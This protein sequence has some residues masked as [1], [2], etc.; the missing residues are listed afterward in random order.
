MER[1]TAYRPSRLLCALVLLIGGCLHTHQQS[2]SSLSAEETEQLLAELPPLDTRAEAKESPSAPSRTEPLRPEKQ[3]PTPAFTQPDAPENSG[4]KQPPTL[5]RHAP[6]GEVKRAQLISLSFSEPMIPIGRHRNNV[7]PPVNLNPAVEGTWRWLDTQS[8]VFEPEGGAFPMATDFTVSVTEK[9][10]SA[11]DIPLEEPFE[12]TFSTPRLQITDFHPGESEPVSQQPVLVI[13]FNQRID[14]DHLINF[15]E[16]TNGEESYSL[17]QADQ[18]R[19][20]RD[21]DGAEAFIDN[22]DYE[23]WLALVPSEPLPQGRSFTLTLREDAPAPA[24]PRRTQTPVTQTFQTAG[25]LQIA[26]LPCGQ[27][28]PCDPEERLLVRL[29]HG[30]AESWDSSLLSISP[31]VPDFRVDHYS[32]SLYLSGDFAPKT[33]YTLTLKAG[34]RDRFGQT[35]QQDLTTRIKTGDYTP[36]FALPGHKWI[37]L[38][39]AFSE[40]PILSRNTDHLRVELRKV[41]PSDWE[42]FT[43]YRQRVRQSSDKEPADKPGELIEM[44]NIRPPEGQRPFVRTDIPLDK[45]LNDAG[46]GHVLVFVSSPD[47][48]QDYTRRHPNNQATMGTWVQVTDLGLSAYTTSRKTTAWVTSLV[49]GRAIEGAQVQFEQA[50]AQTDSRG[51]AEL[52][53]ADTLSELTVTK[54]EDQAFFPSHQ[55]RSSDYHRAGYYRYP[56]FLFSDRGLYQPGEKAHF[57]GIIR[58]RGEGPEGDIQRPSG[59]THIEWT[60]Y[61]GQDNELD[62]GTAPLDKA[63]AFDLQLA[64]PKN[65]ASGTGHI[66]VRLFRG[67][68]PVNQYEAYHGFAIE[69]FRRPEYQ[70]DLQLSEAH[71]LPKE[72]LY[73]AV[74]AHYYSGG[75]LTD[76]P[77]DWQFELKASHYAPPGWPDYQFGQGRPT[78]FGGPGPT[79]QTTTWEES[80]SGRTD[81]AGKHRL[82][83]SPNPTL[84]FDNLHFPHRLNAEAK[85]TDINRQQWASRGE[86]QVHPASLYVGLR[87]HAPFARRGETITV[88]WVTVNI[89]GEAVEA[90]PGF[91]IERME[92]TNDE[93]QVTDKQDCQSENTASQCQFTPEQSGHYRVTA[94]VRDSQ[95]RESRTEMTVWVA[96]KNSSPQ[97]T[98]TGQPEIQMIP[99]KE[100]Y[101]PG[102][103]ARVQVQTPFSPAEL[104]MTVQR[105]GLVS[106][107]YQSLHDGSYTLEIPIRE[108]SMPTLSITAEAIAPATDSEGPRQA[109]QTLSLPVTTDSRRLTVDLDLEQDRLKPGET[110]NVAIA[111]SNHR[112]QP[113][114]GG[115]VTLYAVDEAVLETAGY[116]LPE[117][118]STFYSHIADGVREYRSRDRLVHLPESPTHELLEEVTASGVRASVGMAPPPTD[119]AARSGIDVR[120]DFSALATFE[121]SVKLDENGKASVSFQLPDNLT[122]YRLMAVAYTDRHFGAGESELEVGLPLMVRPSLPRFLNLGDRAELPVVVQNTTDQPMTVDLAL[123]AQNLA[124]SGSLGRRITVPAKDRRELRFAAE[125]I[126]AGEARIQVIARAGDFQDAAELSLPVQTPASAE[127]FAQ[128]GSLTQGNHFLGLSVPEAVYPD[129]GGLSLTT[130]ST[131]IPSLTDAFIHLLDYPYG[132]SEQLASR[133]MAIATLESLITAFDAERI[134]EP[135]AME[136]SVEKILA[137]LKERQNRDGGW[138]FW[139]RNQQSSPYLSTHV[140]HA[141]LRARDAGYSEA[142]TL[143]P[144]ALSYVE[145]LHKHLPDKVGERQRYGALSYSYYV[146]N[147]EEK[148][149]VKQARQLLRQADRDQLSAETLGWLLTVIDD[150]EELQK[151]LRRRLTNRLRETAGTAQF[152]DDYPKGGHWL[153]HGSR[154]TDAVVL[155]ALLSTGHENDLAEKLVRG[156]LDRRKQ[157]HWG[158][159]QENAFALLALKRYFDTYETEQPNLVARAWLDQRF[160]SEHRYRGR[161]TDSHT[162]TLGMGQ[163]QAGNPESTLTLQHQGSGRLYYRLGLKYAPVDMQSKAASHGFQVERRYEAVNNPDEV[164]QR[165]DGSWEIASGAAVRVK[166]TM[167]I[168]ARRHHVALTDHLPAGL[169]PL[170]PALENTAQQDESRHRQSAPGPWPVPRWYQHHQLRDDRAEA[171]STQLEAGVYHYEYIALAT[172]PGRFVV[173]PAEAEEMYRPETFGRSA[174]DT[175][176]VVEAF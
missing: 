3:K 20:Q 170:N 154:R 175:L 6:Q 165:A 23:H 93:W 22:L 40:L 80:A 107:H 112:D 176:R 90:E 69:E 72:P 102:D 8:L 136:T 58:E 166:L 121:S 104:L 134:P 39:G 168:P 32:R 143:L 117:P 31:E 61:D 156:L 150:S 9:F 21:T 87:T 174:T 161:T 88:E 35:L 151:D 55:L 25:E 85:V 158:T 42:A 15:L 92:W 162:E 160:L 155:D 62:N 171:F 163:L 41:T 125:P 66:V 47:S 167:T 109:F 96:G 14:A 51:L 38:P 116:E 50:S 137:Q 2:V 24:G 122:R 67:E 30:L 63:G 44:Q 48:K 140:T 101:A 17:E 108:T 94:S 123:R 45:A 71:H 142:T 74:N 75:P 73:A 86:L 164:R 28:S 99:D 76:A 128:Y 131:Q 68:G 5:T 84:S 18:A 148:A 110:A 105:Q 127:T 82:A 118:L 145:D 147:L 49:E 106:Q 91:K 60:A 138:G 64:L 114:T 46:F 115:E 33:E 172:T 152:V 27:Q 36:V 111:V 98:S 13:G 59:L 100:E 133:L 97:A 10:A 26:K 79:R 29:S 139:T 52:D 129:F 141:L 153:L 126:H 11:A 149:P 130:S 120:S 12:W 83:L 57:K 77:V 34:T 119:T 124:L 95:D 89:E 132:C 135:E 16:L 173:P 103:T 4:D 65:A 78:W 146:L 81:T 43:Q 169:E 56:T 7:Q 113:P 1:L 70:V 54:N 37:S 19:L 159:T 53:S 144:P 157:G